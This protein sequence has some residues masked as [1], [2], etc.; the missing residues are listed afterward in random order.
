MKNAMEKHLN[1]QELI[2]AAQREPFALTGH[3]ES[4]AECRDAVSLLRVFQ[5][6]GRLPL[7]DAPLALVER[8]AS[9]AE[10]TSVWQRIKIV[11][12]RLTFD[13]WAEPQP[14]G[15]RDQSALSDRRI[16]FESEN[17]ILDFRAERG[18]SQWAFVAHVTGEDPSIAGMLLE[19]GKQKLQPDSSGLFYWTSRRPPSTVTICS[20]DLR[21]VTPELSWKRP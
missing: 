13:S 9:L 17:L 1:R 19:V 8:A 10:A 6:H 14:V 16:R 4:C 12:S 11:V 3:L 5:V 20:G 7:P 15:V 2:Q 21:I 18:V